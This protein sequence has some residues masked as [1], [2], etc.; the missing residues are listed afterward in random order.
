[1]IKFVLAAVAVAGIAAGTGAGIYFA[2]PGGE[3]EI[4]RQVQTAT[5]T[6]VVTGTP[7]ASPSPVASA[8][9]ASTPGPLTYTDPTYGYSFDYPAT[10]YLSAPK[11]NGGPV[12][13]YSYDPAKIP[14]EEAG[15]PVPPDK[16]KVEI[17]VFANPQ[18]LSLDAWVAEDRQR[19]APVKVVSRS[20]LTLD[21]IP[22]ISETIKTDGGS[23]TQ[24]FFSEAGRIYVMNAY[25]AV[26][27]LSATFDATL[28]SF[29]FG[30]PG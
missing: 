6:P 10:W 30:P 16:L 5:P 7:G 17:L 3:E 19:G 22:G 13:L 12:V 4:A 29:H 27:A 24:Y 25:P 2:L 20:S 9:P 1:M 26:S 14:P 11:D 21:S 8:T 28:A 23:A 18:N 15:M